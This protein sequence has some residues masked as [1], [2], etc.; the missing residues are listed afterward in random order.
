[1]NIKNIWDLAGIGLILLV[2]F[3]S[4]HTSGLDVVSDKGDQ[5]WFR[6]ANAYYYGTG[7]Y[8]ILHLFGFFSWATTCN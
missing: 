8:F 6:I 7:T 1:M 4:Y 5:F 2:A 3:R